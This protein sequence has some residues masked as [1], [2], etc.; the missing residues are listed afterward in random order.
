NRDER[1][2]KYIRLLEQKNVD[3]ML[4]GTGV[5]NGGILASLGEKSLPIVMIAREAAAIAAHSVVTDDFKGGALAAGHLLDLGH[6]RMAVLAEDMKV[7][8][9][10]ERV[11][12][13]RFG[14]F[15]S[16]LALGEDL[17]FSC[18]SSIKD[19]RRAAA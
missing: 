17:I 12:G 11:R 2:E 6:R 7:T 10:H 19:G 8:S 16:G 15:E 18:E 14:L 1:V 4:I 5:E 9:S 13:F 3:G